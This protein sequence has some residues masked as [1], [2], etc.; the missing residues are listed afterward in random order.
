MVGGG[1]AAWWRAVGRGGRGG[2][3]VGHWGGGA[4]SGGLC[5]VRMSDIQVQA[6]YPQQTNKQIQPHC[7]TPLPHHRPP[8]YLSLT[9]TTI[10]IPHMHQS[11]M[12]LPHHFNF[13]RQQCIPWVLGGCPHQTDM[14]TRGWMGRG[15][16]TRKR[17]LQGPS[18]SLSGCRRGC[19]WVYSNVGALTGGPWVAKPAVFCV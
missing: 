15:R 1:N 10:A 4:H 7:S 14:R 8:A 3:C 16:G 13:P 19:R 18:G 17:G 6:R 12:Q 11:D 2:F 5:I 9:T